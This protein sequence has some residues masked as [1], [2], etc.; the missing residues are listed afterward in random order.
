MGGTG[1]RPATLLN[2]GWGHPGWC[3]SRNLGW[4]REAEHHYRLLTKG[5]QQ[6]A[7]ILGVENS[8]SLV[9]ENLH[10]KKLLDVPSGRGLHLMCSLGGEGKKKRRGKPSSATR[11]W[12]EEEKRTLKRRKGIK[13]GD[14]LLSR[15]KGGR[16]QGPD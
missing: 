15:K 8:A 16:P 13:E 11:S 3:S 12:G 10:E 7:R 2:I 9:T 5:R 4:K 14:V 1:S 6:N